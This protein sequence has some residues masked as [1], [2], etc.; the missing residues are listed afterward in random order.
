MKKIKGIKVSI[1][2]DL[3]A[4]MESVRKKFEKKGVSMRQID[5]SKYLAKK[6][7]K[8]M[9]VIGYAKKIKQKR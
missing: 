4:E 2:P 8:R 9:G 5:V 3:Y 1:H 7:N 6:L